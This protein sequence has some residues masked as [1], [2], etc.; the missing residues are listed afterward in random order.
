ME[1]D[2][3]AGMVFTLCLL[4]QVA[5]LLEGGIVGEVAAQIAHLIEQILPG[6]MVDR[7]GLELAAARQEALHHGVE[8]VAPLI[9]GQVGKIDTDQGEILRQQVADREVVERRHDEPL[10]QIA[11][12][13]K[14][15]HGAGAG[16]LRFERLVFG[17]LLVGHGLSSF[18]VSPLQ[19]LAAWARAT[20][21]TC[22][23]VKPNLVSNPFR[24]AE[25]PNVCM[26]TTA[27]WRPT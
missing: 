19:C 10:G 4:Q 24:C 11:A 9:N 3:A 27:P 5:E 18:S 15:H 6:V 22:S 25:A 1:Q 12:R 13:T 16:G 21:T 26:S 17:G 20:S 7:F 8:I 23:G 2:V 14:N